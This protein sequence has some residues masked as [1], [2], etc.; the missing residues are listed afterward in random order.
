MPFSPARLVCWLSVVDG[1]LGPEGRDERLTA[2]Q[3][4]CNGEIAG[5]RPAPG[6]LSPELRLIAS[7]RI[8][9]PDV[10]LR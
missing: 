8:F 5:W 4:T 10:A 3:M 9:Y 2:V 6:Q 1:R 7:T